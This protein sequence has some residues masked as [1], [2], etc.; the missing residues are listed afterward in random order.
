MFQCFNVQGAA[1]AAIY[2]Y[3]PLRVAALEPQVPKMQG[4]VSRGYV[5]LRAEALRPLPDLQGGVSRGYPY[6]RKPCGP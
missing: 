2:T 3:L 1:A 5:C 6:G 4:G